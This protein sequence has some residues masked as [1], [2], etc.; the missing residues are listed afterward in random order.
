VRKSSICRLEA[1][2]GTGELNE[3]EMIF[4]GAFPPDS[5]PAKVV[6]P[7]VGSFDDP[8]PGLLT[9]NGADEGGLS[10]APNVRPDAAI[11]SFAFGL[12]VVVPFVQADVL[13]TSG[14]SRC[15]QRNRVQR[16]ADHVHVVDVCPRERH[17]QRDALAVGQDVAFC[18]QF[19]AIGR[20]GAGEVPPFG[21][22]TLALSSDAQSHS[23]P[24]LSS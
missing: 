6:V 18:A 21:A 13:R 15:T 9:S 23:I 3:G 7:A 14:S 11:A 2:Q 16:L 20:I 1:N 8:A 22:L 12:L 17:G 10:A 24:T 19:C 4:G 5:Q